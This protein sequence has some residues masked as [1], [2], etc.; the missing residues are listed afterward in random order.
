MTRM[1][2]LTTDERRTLTKASRIVSR[3]TYRIDDLLTSGKEPRLDMRTGHRL[4][5]MQSDI[6]VIACTAR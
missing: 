2:Q 3:L 1:I 6:R 4:A 5:A